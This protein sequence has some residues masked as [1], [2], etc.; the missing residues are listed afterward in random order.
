[1]KKIALSITIYKLWI[2][3]YQ[4]EVVHQRDI[5]SNDR[6]CLALVW[7]EKQGLLT[8]VGEPI[9]NIGP[10][11]LSGYRKD[12]LK[13]VNFGKLHWKDKTI[14]FFVTRQIEFSI[15]YHSDTP[16]PYFVPQDKLPKDFDHILAIVEIDFAHRL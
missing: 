1:M 6:V 11:K 8:R 3:V 9:E 4:W 10:I 16:S 7:A 13:L 14:L 5:R 2:S 12:L 15:S